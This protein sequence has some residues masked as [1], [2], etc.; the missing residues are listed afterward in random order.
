M[1]H[2]TLPLPLGGGYSRLRRAGCT[3]TRSLP[4]SSRLSGSTQREIG[5]YL[6]SPKP[7]TGMDAPELEIASGRETPSG[8][9]DTARNG[10]N[11]VLELAF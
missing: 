4:V 9:H 6:C 11:D 2:Y 5:L 1:T 7:N 10:N 8:V 3:R